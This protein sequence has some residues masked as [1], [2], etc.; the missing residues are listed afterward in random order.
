MYCN[1]CGKEIDENAK[2][3]DGCG[4]NLQQNGNIMNNKLLNN[5]VLDCKEAIRR[6]FSK[7]PI[8]ILEM[9]NKKDSKIGIIFIIITSLLFGFVTCINIAQVLNYWS[10][11]A[12]TSIEGIL[13]KLLGSI[14]T[15]QIMGS[16]EQELS[17]S[18]QK[19]P[20]P[21]ELFLP[22]VIIALAIVG[23]LI[24]C[25]H[26][27]FRFKKIKLKPL[28]VIFNYIGLTNFPIVLSLIINVVIGL[29]FPIFTPFF[30]VLG[31]LISLIYLY[32]S[33]K[34]IF[35]VENPIIRTAIVYITV[36]IVIAIAISIG[37]D[38]VGDKL[39]ETLSNETGGFLGE[40]FEG[41]F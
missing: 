17:S 22:L 27:F 26:I 1:N 28:N 32:E 19:I 9:A 23:I 35:E 18:F 30:F 4:T 25:I 31:I 10:Q 15:G 11:N 12:I 39:L 21:F 29:L 37:L 41:A 5:T 8:S 20:V 38:M 16:L 13:E 34:N 6:F 33:L 40:L 7:K 36:L 2:F 24:G 3:C 14:Y